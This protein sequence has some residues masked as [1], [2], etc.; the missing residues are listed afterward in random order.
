[1]NWMLFRL[2]RTAPNQAMT[3]ALLAVALEPGDV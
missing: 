2:V 3:A 1:M